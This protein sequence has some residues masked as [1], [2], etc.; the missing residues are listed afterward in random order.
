MIARR[1]LPF[2]AVPALAQTQRPIRMIIPFP[3]GGA[4]DALARM[5]AA[6]IQENL[7]VTVV[8]DNRAGG[9]GVVGTMALLQAPTDGLT[10]MA[11]ASIHVMLHRVLRNVPF[12]PVADMVPIARTARG[13]LLMVVNPRRPER[14][15]TDVIAAARANPRDWSMATSSLGAAGHLAAIAF[16]QA[17]GTDIL[18]VA[19]RSSAAGLTDVAAGNVALMF[20][21]VLAPLPMVR[22]GQLRALAVTDAARIDAVPDV[23]TM[24]EA[25]LPG[26]VFHSWYGIWGARG[27][28]AEMAARINAALQTGMAEPDVAAR[29]AQL[30][31]QPVAESPADFAR[32][33]DEDVTRNT[34]LLG[35]V[36]FQPEG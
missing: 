3:P 28:P 26:F 17:A 18:I 4:T 27:F 15:V 36:N 33:I 7:G 11:S 8:A 35:R 2:L 6:K 25:G 1:A 24:A 31:F 21:P 32:Y 10:I 5:A 13:P 23:P 14:T 9:N 16:N 29:L 30:A 19:Q 20:D 34:A 12:D 22:G